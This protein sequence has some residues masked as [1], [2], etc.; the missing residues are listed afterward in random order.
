MTNSALTTSTVAFRVIWSP[1][2]R[3]K[4]GRE[5]QSQV[6]GAAHKRSERY[7]VFEKT[8]SLRIVLR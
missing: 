7:T 3:Q 8:F 2:I 1:G 4:S 6:V 5:C